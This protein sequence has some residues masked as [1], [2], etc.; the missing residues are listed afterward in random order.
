MSNP[1]MECGGLPPL[2]VA[3]AC[4]RAGTNVSP[5]RTVVGAGP[6]VCPGAGARGKPHA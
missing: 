1:D 2:S 3:G 5:Q 6:C 4:H